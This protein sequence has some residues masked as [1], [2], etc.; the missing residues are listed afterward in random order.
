MSNI[1][2]TNRG[3]DTPGI[4][5][6]VR[7]LVILAVCGI[8]FFVNLG[9]IRLWDRDEPRNAQAALEMQQRGDWIVPSFNEQLRYQKPIL[10]YWL[11]RIAYQWFGVN[12]FAARFWSATLATAAVC[13]L[14]VVVGRALGIAVGFWAAL[15]LAT[16]LMFGVAARA[17]TPDAILIFLYTSAVLWYGLRVLSDLGIPERLNSVSSTRSTCWFN[18]RWESAIFYG[19]LGCGALAKGLAGVILPMAVIGMLMLIKRLPTFSERAREGNGWR[20]YFRGLRAFHPLHFLKTV[21]AMQPLWGALW[22]GLVAAPWFIAV[23]WATDGEFLQRFFV[24]EH[25]GRATTSFESH[26]GGLWYYP[27]T[28]LVGFFPWSLFIVP[29]AM[30]VRAWLRQVSWDAVTRNWLL[31]GL[32]WVGVQVGIFSIAQT[33]LP[34]YVTPC[35]PALAILT[36]WA[37]RR[38]VRRVTLS[39]ERWFRGG[40]YAWL[41]AAVAI[42]GGLAWA[43]REY[44]GGQWQ[45]GAIA[46]PLLLSGIWLVLSRDHTGLARST[47][48]AVMTVGAVAF[49]SALLAW[50]TAQVSATN[51]MDRILSQIRSV[52]PSAGVATFRC[53]E[54][55]WVFYGQHPIHELEWGAGPVVEI[56]P[57]RRTWRERLWCDPSAFA[58]RFREALVIAPR[59]HVDELLSR[60]PAG[61]DVLEE[62]QYFLQDER[63]VLL[64]LRAVEVGKLP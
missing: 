50:G 55:S 19:V 57:A 35:Y 33:K 49:A 40:Y 24:D 36:A 42:T 17:T 63:L 41:L 4:W 9:S 29:V 60:L 6:I 61:G 12:E 46:A 30:E 26:R 52:S 31:L 23:G 10:P 8:V 7:G 21:W 56:D 27:L 34:S 28:L 53:L 62:V 22:I 25:W 58:V 1:G 47:N 15:M 45:L 13:L 43:G 11:I 16:S 2:E 18:N 64:K 3:Y 39:D 32:C 5:N 44:V 20:V 51:E 48:A 37:L 14:A 54:S 59:Q 38:Y